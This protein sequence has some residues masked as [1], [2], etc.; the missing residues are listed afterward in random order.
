M[1]FKDLCAS[2]LI[3]IASASQASAAEVVLDCLVEQ[4]VGFKESDDIWQ[5][6]YSPNCEADT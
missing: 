5:P 3:L 6:F 4:T 2:G 1:M